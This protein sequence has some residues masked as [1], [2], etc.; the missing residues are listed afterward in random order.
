MDDP[1]SYDC[2]EEGT[3]QYSCDRN[4]EWTDEQPDRASPNTCLR[5]SELFD[6]DQVRHIIGTEQEGNKQNLHSPEQPAEGFK[7]E[8]HPV[9]QKAAYQ[10]DDT[11]QDR[12]HKPDKR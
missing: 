2:S 12:V 7:A 8:K 4:D 5:A 11:W 9:Q 10:K 6:T 3:D 1:L